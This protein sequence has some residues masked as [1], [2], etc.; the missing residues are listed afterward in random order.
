[1]STSRRLGSVCN[2]AQSAARRLLERSD[3]PLEAVAWNR[4]LA[5]GSE[6]ELWHAPW[7]QVPRASTVHV[8]QNSGG[9]CG[10]IE[11]ETGMKEQKGEQSCRLSRR[12]QESQ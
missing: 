4:G 11:R 8:F 5:L 9:N 6:C 2:N 1:M 12:T 10:A 3:A 7:P